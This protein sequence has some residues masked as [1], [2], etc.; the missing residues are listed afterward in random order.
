METRFTCLA[1][2]RDTISKTHAEIDLGVKRIGCLL[3][4]PD[5]KAPAQ[6]IYNRARSI[7]GCNR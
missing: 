5:A 2:G 4:N 3:I 1:P 7:K 6:V